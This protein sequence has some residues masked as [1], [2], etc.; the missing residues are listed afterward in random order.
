MFGNAVSVPVIEWLAQR[1]KR[2]SEN[3]RQAV[4]EQLWLRLPTCSSY[5]FEVR[6]GDP[7]AFD[8]FKRHYSYRPYADGRRERVGYRNRWQFVGPGQ[9]QIL[10]TPHGDAL[11]VWRKFIDKSGQCG[12]NCACFRNGS[13]ILPSTL[14]LDAA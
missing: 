10:V 14:I 4:S 6:D 2:I 11:F 7:L 1:I 5:W 12:L 9:K 13:D 8:L 3:Q